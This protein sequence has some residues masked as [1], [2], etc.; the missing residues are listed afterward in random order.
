MSRVAIVH[1]LDRFCAGIGGEDAANLPVRVIHEATGAGRLLQQHLGDR[2]AIVATIVGGD[3]YVNEQQ[4]EALP[5]IRAAL[6]QV[7][8]AALVAGPAFNA[9]RYGAACALA[10]HLATH[11]LSIPS[12]SAMHPENPGARL[13]KDVIVVPT[14]A[15]PSS[16][17]AAMAKVARLALKLGAGE[18]LG[19]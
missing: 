10:G 9:G 14:G 13:S 5:A 12:V 16:M 19:P 6:E 2:G 4:A 11:D 18:A 1:Y 3:N 7:R 15:D 17:A 8:P